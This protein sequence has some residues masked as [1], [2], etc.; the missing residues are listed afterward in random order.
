MNLEDKQTIDHKLSQPYSLKI[1]DNCNYVAL[2]SG[3]S[4]NIEIFNIKTMAKIH[5]IEIHKHNHCLF[6]EGNKAI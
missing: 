2:E 4:P 5:T 6:I 1:T 3:E